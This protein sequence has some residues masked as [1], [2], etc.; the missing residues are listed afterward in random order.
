MFKHHLQLS[1]DLSIVW[2]I[3]R[4]FK[5]LLV[6]KSSFHMCYDASPWT[7]EHP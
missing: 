6:R 1:G 4:D 7:K 5:K 3:T 2:L